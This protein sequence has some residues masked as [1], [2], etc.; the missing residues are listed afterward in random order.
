MNEPFINRIQRLERS[1]RF[2]RATSLVL[3]ALLLS[4]LTTGFFF[5]LAHQ[6]TDAVIQQERAARAQAK[7]ARLQAE[8]ALQAAE[9][10]KKD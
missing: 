9:Q 7:A 4:M 1:N 5:S 3:A 8:R 10:A 2:W 6:R